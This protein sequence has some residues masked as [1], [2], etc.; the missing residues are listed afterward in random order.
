MI[1]TIGYERLARSDLRR[2]MDMLNAD[3]HACTIIDVRMTPNNRFSKVDAPN[4]FAGK[5]L[6]KEYGPRYEE[7]REL[8]GH[9]VECEAEAVEF[10]RE[11]DAESHKHCLLICKEENPGACHRHHAITAPHFPDA[12]HIFRDV[13]YWEV[14]L[15]ELVEHGQEPKNVMALDDVLSVLAPA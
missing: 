14:E 11:Y 6:A 7:H 5:A 3:G 9:N 10:L 12:I 13:A 1:F 4:S 8:G 15:E 2:I